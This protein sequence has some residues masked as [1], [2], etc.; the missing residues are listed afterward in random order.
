MKKSVKLWLD[1]AEYDLESARFMMQGGRY[2]YVAFMCQ[3]SIEKLLKA[4]IQEKT[5]DLPP[6]THNLT[7]L[8]KH[9]D[10]SLS[11]KQLDFLALLNR[12]YL[13]TRYPDHK[14]KLADNIDEKK[15]KELLSTSEGLYQCLLKELT[16]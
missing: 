3:Q 12:Y 1:R 9:V 11:E 6:Y 16:I 5:E 4:I 13:N 8:A 10:L 2:F 7:A 15:A 14:Q